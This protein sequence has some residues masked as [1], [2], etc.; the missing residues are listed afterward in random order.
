MKQY[1][2]ED[3]GTVVVNSPDILDHAYSTDFAFPLAR[4]VPMQPATIDPT[5]DLCTRYTLQLGGLKMKFALLVVFSKCFCAGYS[6]FSTF[7]IRVKWGTNAC[8]VCNLFDIHRWCCG[9]FCVSLLTN[10]R[11]KVLTKADFV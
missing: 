1:N 10:R 8:N 11:L 6:A 9:P 4:W 3:K 7:K 5:L 2:Y